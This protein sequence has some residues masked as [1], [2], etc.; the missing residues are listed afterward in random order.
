MNWA[1]QIDAY[2]ERTDFSLW[3][4][5]INAITNAAFLIAALII[6]RRTSGLM[7]ARA[8]TIILFTIGIGSTLFHTFATTWASTAD[9]VPI[10][11]F[12][13]LYLFLV[14]LHITRWPVW[15]AVIGTLGFIPYAIGIKFV[16]RDIPFFEISSF[17]WA[18]PISLLLYAPFI[19]GKTARGFIFGAA[20]LSLSI[21]LRS[22]DE[23]LCA[24]WPIGTHFAWHILNALMLGYMI[25]VY[26]RHMLEA[27]SI[28][29]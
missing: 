5:P 26:R 1:N 20:L 16:L 2:C 29:G 9:V 8:L 25:D 6:W 11:L 14:H 17:Y 12:I 13:L 23:T 24:Q 7:G 22:L 27:P 10:V 18:V 28:Q 4:E 3:S 15:M 19:G 21:T